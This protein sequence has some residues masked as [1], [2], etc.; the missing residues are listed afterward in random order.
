MGGEKEG[1]AYRSD[2]GDGC[3]S[4]GD[5]VRGGMEREGGPRD[6]RELGE[7]V[8]DVWSDE[9]G[10]PAGSGV[11]LESWTVKLVRDRS[12]V[13]EVASAS[14]SEGIGG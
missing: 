1:F 11:D 12:A 7:E 6:E 14:C 2:G 10:G 9:Q 8:E 5:G 4:G 13:A 3:V